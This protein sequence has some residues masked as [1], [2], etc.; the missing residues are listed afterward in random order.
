MA[1]GLLYVDRCII[2]R[3]RTSAI[4]DFFCIKAEG[5]RV[6][7]SAVERILSSQLLED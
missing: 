1:E 5:V 3:I 7:V 4:I 6:A 2:F